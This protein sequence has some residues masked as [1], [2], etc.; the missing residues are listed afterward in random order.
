MRVTKNLKA[1]FPYF[2]GKSKVA[3]MVWERLGDVANYVEPFAGSL[4]VLLGRPEGRRAT[5]TVN[6]LNGWLVN[7]WRALAAD[8]EAVA[9]AADW[10]VSELDLHA[11]GDAIFY[12]DAWHAARG[13]ESVAAWVEWLRADPGHYDAQVAGWWVWG[14]CSWIGTGWGHVNG[15]AAGTM[16]RR[17]KPHLGNAGCG[18]NRQLPHLGNAGLGVYFV[19]L[20]ERLRRVRICCG[21]WGRVCGPSVTH[22]HGLTG[23]FLDPPY[24]VEDRAD[25]YADESRT[26]AADVRVWAIEAGRN[27]LMRVVLC[28]Y[29]GEHAMPKDWECVAWKAAGGFGSQR[30][31]GS[32]DNGAQERIW[33]SPHC[34][35]SGQGELF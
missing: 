5:E 10:P 28:G 23:V 32:N 18:V 34:L 35:S 22:K 33:F 12:R 20:A 30:R 4:A 7:F 31:D 9:A 24:G 27:P 1:P 8:P 29:E 15:N 25:T 17:M 3:H 16:T 2:G 26:V 21:D 14:Q 19:E 11:R 6:D 13:H